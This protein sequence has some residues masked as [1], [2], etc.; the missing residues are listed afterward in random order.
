MRFKNLFRLFKSDETDSCP[1]ET[2]E[3]GPNQQIIKLS[4]DMQ[5]RIEGLPPNL[6]REHRIKVL[7]SLVRNALEV[8]PERGY[9]KGERI[10]NGKAR[11]RVID[12]V[13]DVE[14]SIEATRVLT[15][16]AIY[17]EAFD[18]INAGAAAGIYDRELAEMTAEFVKESAWREV[19]GFRG[20]NKSTSREGL[21]R[22]EAGDRARPA[23]NEG[24]SRNKEP[25]LLLEEESTDERRDKRVNRNRH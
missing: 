23:I 11:L 22:E 25:I 7:G 4:E 24:G 20:H 18:A 3:S 13:Y 16:L 21:G 1:G 19:E 2:H 17:K 14:F 12:R 5:L 10:H 8:A 6:S 9:A 15:A